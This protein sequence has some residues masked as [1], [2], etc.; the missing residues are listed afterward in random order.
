MSGIY[1]LFN[2]NKG[3]DVY[4][5]ATMHLILIIVEP[6]RPR[7]VLTSDK[8]TW[9][10]DDSFLSFV[11][12]HWILVLYAIWHLKFCLLYK[13]WPWIS[14]LF[15]LIIKKSENV[16]IMFMLR[17]RNKGIGGSW[18]ISNCSIIFFNL[19]LW[20][21]RSLNIMFLFLVHPILT[22]LLKYCWM[23]S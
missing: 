13:C 21:L 12:G 16:H 17:E 19:F 22:L 15:D 18:T 23:S 7:Y 2:S 9:G 8:T 1:R 4:C 14:N 5:V 3:W 10:K 20:A 6:S 11:S